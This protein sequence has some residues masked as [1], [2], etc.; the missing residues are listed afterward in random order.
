MGHRHAILVV[1]DDYDT[2]EALVLLIASVGM[3]VVEAA[4]GREALDRLRGGFR[5]CFI[6]LDMAMPVMNGAAFRRA[7]LADPALAHIPVAALSAGGWVGEQEA[8]QV[9]IPLFLRKPLDID[10]LVRLLEDHYDVGA[11]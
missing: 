4:N 1:E 2:R 3:D 6:L 8:K 10:R 5:P 9:G 11:S 7:Q